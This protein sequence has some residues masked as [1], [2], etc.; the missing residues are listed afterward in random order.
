MK[1]AGNVASFAKNNGSIN[2]VL[3]AMYYEDPDLINAAE[4]VVF[5]T[6]VENY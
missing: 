3:Q 5:E 6:S 2:N 1:V 4:T